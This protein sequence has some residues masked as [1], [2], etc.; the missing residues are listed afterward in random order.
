MV[1]V[2]RIHISGLVDCRMCLIHHYQTHSAISLPNKRLFVLVCDKSK[3]AT[4]YN[5]AQNIMEMIYIFLHSL[6]V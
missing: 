3:A 1:F 2:S 5:N 6:A 4:I